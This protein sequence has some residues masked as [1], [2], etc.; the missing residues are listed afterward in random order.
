MEKIMSYSL[1]YP[2]KKVITDFYYVAF[3]SCISNSRLINALKSVVNI[4][5][6]VSTD[7]VRIFIV[8]SEY[9]MEILRN[10]L[11]K[12]FSPNESFDVFGEGYSLELCLDNISSFIPD[13][14]QY[15][16]FYQDIEDEKNEILD[17]QKSKA[18]NLFYEK[19]IIYRY[20]E[21]QNFIDGKSIQYIEWI[22]DHIVNNTLSKLNINKTN[23]YVYNKVKSVLISIIRKDTRHCN[24]REFKILYDI[25]QKHKSG[26][27]NI[28]KQLDTMVCRCDLLLGTDNFIVP[29]ENKYNIHCTRDVYCGLHTRQYITGCYLRSDIIKNVLLGIFNINLY[30]S[31]YYYGTLYFYYGIKKHIPEKAIIRLILEK[32]IYS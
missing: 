29:L 16:Q 23:F 18:M 14:P 2:N 28:I 11:S 19:V 22:M 1:E 8:N 26:L 12:L 27:K 13:M 4:Y 5:N 9:Q 25:E 30:K 17:K 20:I 21:F 3:K 15:N 31:I 7:L 6:I 32:W 10:S 24:D